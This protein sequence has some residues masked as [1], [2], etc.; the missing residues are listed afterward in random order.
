M[1]HFIGV[2]NDME[3]VNKTTKSIV[4]LFADDSVPIRVALVAMI[5]IFMIVQLE[6][7]LPGYVM[8]QTFNKM[9]ETSYEVERIIGE[10]K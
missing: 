4:S 10:N 1:K 7:K 3:A 6:R 8:R 2:D 9:I 5:N